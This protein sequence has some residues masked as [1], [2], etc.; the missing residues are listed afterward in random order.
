MRRVLLWKRPKL[1]F[2]WAYKIG[3]CYATLNTVL[4]L[5]LYLA[6]YG[7]TLRTHRKNLARYD[8]NHLYSLTWHLLSLIYTEMLLKFV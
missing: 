1:E 3:A 5:V 7:G 4:T 2:D 6:I 8:I